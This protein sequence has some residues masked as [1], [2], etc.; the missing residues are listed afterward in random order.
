MGWWVTKPGLVCGA[1]AGALVFT[2]PAAAEGGFQL[3][4]ASGP[5]PFAPGCNGAPA[6]DTGTLYRNAEVEPYVAVDPRNSNHIGGVWE[7]DR[8]SNGGAN[9]LMTG[10]SHDG[11]KSG[12]PKFAHFSGCAG[13][14]PAQGGD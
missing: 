5:P 13:G 2:R 12:K 1:M 11:G 4:R 9:G 3:A 8:W 6:N 7:Q 14:N 10:V